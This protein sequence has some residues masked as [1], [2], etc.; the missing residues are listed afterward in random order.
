MRYPFKSIGKN[1]K[2]YPMAKIVGAK[3]IE[4][5]SNVIID[6][7]V[8]IVA[9]KRTV[10]GNYVHVASFT[11]ITGGGE[12]IL[13]DFVTLSSGI[14]LITGSDSFHGDGLTNSTIPPKYR[15]VSR[16]KILIKKHAILGMNC[17]VLPGILISEG[18]AVGAGS[19]VTKNISPWTIS[20]GS[21]ARKIRVRPSS[22]VLSFEKQLMEELG[23]STERLYQGYEL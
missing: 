18:A 2:I 17:I 10:I 7:F 4:I 21:P 16:S 19:I 8:F 15:S 12:C 3:N 5:G 1:V 23:S 22:K 9:A 11:S 6:D 20:A 14:R 13:E